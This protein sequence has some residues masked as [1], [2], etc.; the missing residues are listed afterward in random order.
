MKFFLDENFPKKVTSL[1]EQLGHT[2]FDIRGTVQEG[3]S[4]LEIF[5]LAKKEKAIFLTSDKD[6]YH[7]I[8]LTEKPHYGIIVIALRQ[9]NSG[10]I[11]EKIIWVLNNLEKFS[12]NNECLLLTDN[13]CTVF[14]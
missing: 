1:L 3:I 7:T 6:F 13:K 14:K 10:A 12:F 8:H 4:D 5:S 2:V 9:P 11:I